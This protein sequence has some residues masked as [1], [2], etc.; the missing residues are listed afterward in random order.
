[1]SSN[2]E[3]ETKTKIEYSKNLALIQA[4]KRYYEKNK[5]KILSRNTEYRKSH[6]DI[7]KNYYEKNKE[8]ILI[9]IKE[10][11]KNNKDVSRAYYQKNKEKQKLYHK[12]RRERI[13]KE[14]ETLKMI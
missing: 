6:K 12:D 5:E 4:Q 2:I 11:R 10:Y 14:K 13:K 7:S 3:N 1:M 8:Q 9:N